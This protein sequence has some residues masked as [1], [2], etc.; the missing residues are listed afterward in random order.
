MTRE[1]T[2]NELHRAFLEYE[3]ERDW[4]PTAAFKEEIWKRVFEV[5]YS[6]APNVLVEFYNSMP[7]RIADLITQGKV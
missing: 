1:Y 5:W 2:R 3:E 4:Q 7:R 6:E